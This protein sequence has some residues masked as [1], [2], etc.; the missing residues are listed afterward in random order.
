MYGRAL[1]STLTVALLLGAGAAVAQQGARAELTIPFKATAPGRQTGLDMDLRYLHPEDRD[2]KPPTISKLAIHLPEGTRIDPAAVPACEASNE[3]IQA[4]G[5]DAC[6]ADTFVGDGFLDV[7]LGGPGD[8]QRTDVVLFN[9]PG[10]LIEVVF[11]EGTNQTA[12][13]ERLR[14]EGSTISGE[15]VQVPPGAPPEQRFSASRIVWDIPARGDYLV[16]P[17]SCDGTWTTR[18]EFQFADGSSARASYT[19]ECAR[20]RGEGPPATVPPSH[21]D[22]GRAPAGSFRVRVRPRVVVRGRRTPL[23]VRV[24]SDEPACRRGIVRVGRRSARTRAA[25]RTSLVALVRWRRPLARVRVATR[26]GSERALLRV[27]SGPGRPS[28]SGRAAD[29]VRHERPPRP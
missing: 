14:V 5:R 29:R 22:P 27:R 4:R 11:F 7:Y 3:E 25:G 26:C 9:G 24:L 12:A 19:Q 23:R 10:Q 20:G 8:P 18:G 17:P 28:S 6:P 15:P 13:I 1:I 2:G 21:G 16:T